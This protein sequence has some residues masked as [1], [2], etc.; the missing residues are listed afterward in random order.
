M[1]VRKVAVRFASTDACQSS[2]SMSSSGP[3]RTGLPPALATR[4]STSAETIGDD[5]PHRLDLVGSG[6]VGDDRDG[7][8]SLRLDPVAHR[9][10][11]GTV[12]AVHHHRGTLG[13]EQR[14][15]GRPDA[16]GAPGDDSGAVAQLVHA[17]LLDWLPTFV[18]AARA[19]TR[20]WRCRP[21]RCPGEVAGR[22]PR[23]RVA[24]R[25]NAA[26]PSSVS[27]T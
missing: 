15:D 13:G 22:I 27:R 5:P 9:V 14:R 6:E 3:G 17:W 18:P 20:T 25:A 12:P 21:R 1:S 24:C 26:S 7:S 11:G 10:G 2:S 23:R 19:R 4:M 16:T 8:P